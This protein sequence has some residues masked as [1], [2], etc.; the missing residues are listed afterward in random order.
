MSFTAAKLG[1]F[2]F[3]E[4]ATV[5]VVVSGMF[6]PPAIQNDLGKYYV[7]G[8]LEH[9]IAPK[10]DQ[11]AIIK[12]RYPK[13]IGRPLFQHAFNL[14]WFGCFSYYCAYLLAQSSKGEKISDM[15]P[16]LSLIPWLADWGYFMAIDLPELGGVPAQAQTYIVT[17]AC[18]CG[19]V[20]TAEQHG[21]SPNVLMMQIGGF[22]TLA[23]AAIVN[24]ISWKMGWRKRKPT[25]LF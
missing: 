23:L 18:I 12:G 13:W 14:G 20:V 24:K 4:W 3:F 19:A 8:L 9:G 11:E 1:A 10:E 5:H 21:T 2:C 17:I 22:S 16:V 6:M 15:F 7:P 25:S